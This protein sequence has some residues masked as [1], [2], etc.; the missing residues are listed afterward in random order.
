MPKAFLCDLPTFH[1]TNNSLYGCSRDVTWHCHNTF[2][3]T[4]LGS[5]VIH[6]LLMFALISSLQTLQDTIH[7]D[8]T[9][10]WGIFLT[11]LTSHQCLRWPCELVSLCTELPTNQLFKSNPQFTVKEYRRPNQEGSHKHNRFK[12]AHSGVESDERQVAHCQIHL[13]KPALDTETYLT[14]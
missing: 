2:S 13:L 5:L 11:L 10:C 9:S 8:G 3:A 14:P 6:L 1:S 7:C 4:V 12:L